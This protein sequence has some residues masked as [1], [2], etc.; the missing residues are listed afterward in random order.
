MNRSE[1]DLEKRDLES[2]ASGKPLRVESGTKK[3]E[4]SQD[5]VEGCSVM[6]YVHEIYGY[7]FRP[8]YRDLR[9]LT[10]CEQT[11]N[12]RVR[13]RSNE[14]IIITLQQHFT[15]ESGN[16]SVLWPMVSLAIA[17][18]AHA[19]P[20][21]DRPDVAKHVRHCATCLGTK[22]DT[23]LPAGQLLSKVVTATR[24]WQIINAD[25]IG[26]LP[27]SSK[28]Y[29]FILFVCDTFSKFFLLFSL[30]SSTVSSVAQVMEDHVYFY[31]LVWIYGVHLA[32]NAHYHPQ[33]SPMEKVNHVIKGMLR[34]YVQDNHRS[35]AQY[36]L[37]IGYA[38][39]SAK[40]DT[41]FPNW[42]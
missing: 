2:L 12:R 11:D 16:V 24:P 4:S 37:K 10:S 7:T 42:K 26:S 41:S 22:P 21:S 6:H 35:W 38:V 31:D 3:Y 1:L 32:Y 18:S 34:A 25:L 13:F 28:G 19:E 15:T 36:L 14:I 5:D 8:P 23:Q 27:R 17:Y 40:F 9:R 29:T 20:T 33:C 30:R 39:R